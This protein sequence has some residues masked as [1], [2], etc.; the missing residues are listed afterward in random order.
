M[1][2]PVQFAGYV[3][4]L[5]TPAALLVSAVAGLPA[6]SAGSLGVQVGIVLTLTGTVTAAAERDRVIDEF[7]LDAAGFDRTDGIDV[8]AVT[9]GALVTY[10]ASVGAELGPVLA[11]ALVGLAAG[12]AL[13][14]VAV[15]LYCG[16]FVGMAS[17]AVFPGPEFVAV[18]GLLAGLAFVATAESFGG[19]GGKLGTIALFG[20]TT[21]VAC[22]GL[23]YGA[24]SAPAWDL[25]PIVVPVAAVAAVATVVL[26]LHLELGAVVG[27]ALVGTV[28]GIAFPFLFALA[29]LGTTLATVAFCASFVGMSSTERLAT[30]GHVGV[31]GGLCGLVYL[32]VMPSVAGAGGK[33]GT[34]A[35]VSCI[36]LVGLEEVRDAVAV[37]GE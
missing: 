3:A 8:V 18:A 23:E 15:P 6:L 11:S 12:L 24:T 22:L 36:A 35:F 5:L 16:S 37:S 26:S 1:Y 31:A 2:R 7:A 4:L 21:T 13:P 20:C 25:V 17:P 9:V 19:F 34:T 29:E 27:S 14:R 32:A 10:G 30:A 28:A 33:L